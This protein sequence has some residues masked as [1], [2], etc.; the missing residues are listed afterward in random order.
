MDLQLPV[1][2]AGL[3]ILESQKIDPV[4]FGDVLDVEVRLLPQSYRVV[5]QELRVVGL[6]VGLDGG[7]T[8]DD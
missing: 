6:R 5:Q 2:P 7:A 3:D 4:D 1:L 8:A